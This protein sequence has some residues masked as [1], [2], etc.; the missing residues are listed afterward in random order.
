MENINLFGPM[1]W[2]MLQSFLCFVFLFFW[3]FFP[4]PQGKERVTDLFS[5]LQ[6]CLRFERSW[7]WYYLQ[8]WGQDKGLENKAHFSV[9]KWSPSEM[10]S[11]WTGFLS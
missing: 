4:I 2:F 11:P 3:V 8:P 9:A 5:L 10:P 7:H 1:V 6:W